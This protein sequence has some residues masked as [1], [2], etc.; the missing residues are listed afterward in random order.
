MK[1]PE[2]FAIEGRAVV[3]KD[4]VCKLNDPFYGSKQL[5]RC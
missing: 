5:P 4:Y 2:G 3:Q 1:V